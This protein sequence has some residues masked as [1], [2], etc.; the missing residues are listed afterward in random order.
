M[1]FNIKRKSTSARSLES[2]R[3]SGHMVAASSHSSG[4]SQSMLS[5]SSVDSEVM[6]LQSRLVFAP[7]ISVSL[8]FVNVCREIVFLFG[9]TISILA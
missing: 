8:F 9:S 7:G 1:T 4:S 5:V 3:S 6:E 2:S